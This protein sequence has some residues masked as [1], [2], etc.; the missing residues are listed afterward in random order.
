MKGTLKDMNLVQTPSGPKI[1]TVDIPL[2]ASKPQ[3]PTSSATVSSSEGSSD[4]V[5]SRDLALHSIER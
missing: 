4:G 1:V 3:T 5:N 2:P